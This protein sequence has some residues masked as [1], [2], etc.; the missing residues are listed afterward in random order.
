MIS[1]NSQVR[2]NRHPIEWGTQWSPC[3][4]SLVKSHGYIQI[5]LLTKKAIALEKNPKNFSVLEVVLIIKKSSFLKKDFSL[6]LFKY[7]LN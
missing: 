7:L 6:E 1:K 5:T 4:A 3:G 2:G